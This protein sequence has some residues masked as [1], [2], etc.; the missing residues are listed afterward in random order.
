MTLAMAIALA[1]TSAT[2]IVDASRAVAAAPDPKTNETPK[3]RQARAIE[4]FGR[5]EAQFRDGRYDAAARLFQEAWD[6]WKDPAYLFNIG[7]AFEK[8]GRWPLAV[9]W[10]GRFLKEYPEVP[11]ASDVSRRR[12]AAVKSREASR[13]Q[14]MVTSSPSGARAE[15]P[16]D[17]TVQ[18]CTT[19]CLLRVD[20]GPVTVKVAL[21]TKTREVAR[22]IDRSERWDLLVDLVN[23]DPGPGHKDPI[24]PEPEADR[25]GAIVAWSLGGAGLVVGTIFGIMANGDYDDGSALAAKNGGNLE[26]GDY[27][28]LGGLRSDLKRDSMVA[29]IGFG[30]ALVGAVVGTVLWIVSEPD[31]VPATHP[32]GPSPSAPRTGSLT[33]HF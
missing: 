1:L 5:G 14:I 28:R 25:T 30:T 18:P 12:D 13:A 2:F 23:F 15:I 22:S 19:P 10:Y 16:S 27:D 8:A 29:D 20:P 33:W 6:A 4:T 31:P 21:G 7:L 3:E 26:K 32:S 9:E 17:A 24:V 11:N